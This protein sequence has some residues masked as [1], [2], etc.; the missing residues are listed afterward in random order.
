MNPAAH[1]LQSLGSMDLFETLVDDHRLISRVLNAFGG[2]L[3]EAESSGLL[4]A[5]ELNRFVVFFREFVELL[6]HE[7][8]EEVLFPAME[9]IGYSKNGAPLAHIH[10]QH[11]RE[12]ALLLRLRKLA[13]ATSPP[14]AARQ[15]R[16]I[17]T[18]RELV[19]F[20]QAHMQKENELLYPAMK[21][22]FSGQTIAALSRKMNTGQAAERRATD[23][24][25]L[26]T[27]ADELA[28]A[29]T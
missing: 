2:F 21:K 23:Q 16:L 1:A 8:E 4:D 13:V 6:H 15:A 18:G 17:E 5:V 7:R 10:D 14:A 11:E 26:K 3:D 22:E 27:L 12:C 25:W 20:E 19:E 24:A 9:S 29:H 28:R